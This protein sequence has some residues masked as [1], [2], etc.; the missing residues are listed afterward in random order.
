MAASR[1]NGIFSTSTARG[2][3]KPAIRFKGQKSSSN[4]THGS[5][6]T[7]GFASNPSAKKTSAAQYDR[8]RA[9]G[10][11]ADA[12]LPYAHNAS[13]QNS[14]LNTSLR[15]AIHA[16]DSTCN[17][18]SANSAATNALRHAMPVI[19]RR[20]ANNSAVFAPWNSTFT[21][22]C[23]PGRKPKIWQSSMC[24]NHVSGCQLPATMAVQAHATLLQ[25]KPCCTTGFSATYA[26]SSKL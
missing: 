6:T 24:D 1:K 11:G 8:D 10:P 19:A 15:S 2:N 26:Q 20:T 7:I 16:T 17:G 5:V 9:N 22:W 21:R 3:G 18:C 13:I 4:N 25:V 14:V 23:P 12:C